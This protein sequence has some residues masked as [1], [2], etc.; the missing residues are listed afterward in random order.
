[1][2]RGRFLAGGIL[3]PA[4]EDRYSRLQDEMDK[5]VTEL[6]RTRDEALKAKNN[7]AE[8]LDNIAHQMK[9]SITAISLSVQMVKHTA[10]LSHLAKIQGQLSRL[11]RLEE[12]LLA[13]SRIDAGTLPMAR[14]EIDVFTLLTLAADQLQELFFKEKVSMSI[15]ESGEA[16]FNGDMDWTMEAISNLWNGTS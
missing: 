12:S 7:F 16:V 11:T 15:P 13:L 1:M 4:R 14:R 3:L 2:R 6:Y 9:T 8:N 10:S 5:T